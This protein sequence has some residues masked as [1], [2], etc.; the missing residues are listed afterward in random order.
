VFD[1]LGTDKVF[2]EG[3]RDSWILRAVQAVKKSSTD[4]GFVEDA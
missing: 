4:Q 2:F 1:A 3:K